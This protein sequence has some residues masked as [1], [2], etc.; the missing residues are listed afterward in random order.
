MLADLAGK[1]ECLKQSEALPHFWR[2]SRGLTSTL[3]TM[4][5]STLPLLINASPTD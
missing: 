4:N 3:E 2:S 5:A 1:S